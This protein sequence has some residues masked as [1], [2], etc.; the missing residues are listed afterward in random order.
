M[1]SFSLQAAILNKE[2]PNGMKRNISQLQGCWRRLKIQLKKGHD[3]H[4]RETRK[5]G[6]GRPPASPSEG[7]KN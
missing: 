6:G 7:S 2:N 3:L 1:I 4:R 5:T